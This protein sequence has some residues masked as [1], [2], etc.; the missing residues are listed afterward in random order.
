MPAGGRRTP[1]RGAGQD[2]RTARRRITVDDDQVTAVQVLTGESLSSGRQR[3]PG[4]EVDRR[5]RAGALAPSSSGNRRGCVPRPWCRSG[6]DMR[7]QAAHRHAFADSCRGTGARS[8]TS[9]MM[10][11]GELTRGLSRMQLSLGRRE[12]VHAQPRSPRE[13]SHERRSGHR[14]TDEVSLRNGE[15]ESSGTASGAKPAPSG[16]GAFGKDADAGTSCQFSDG[17][18]ER[19]RVALPAVDRYLPHRV[20]HPAEHSVLPPRPSG[21]RAD[22]SLSA[23]GSTDD[24]WIPCTVVI[25]QQQRGTRQREILRPRYP[26]PSP[27]AQH[28]P[29]G[30]QHGTVGAWYA[31]LDHGP[32]AHR[33]MRTPRRHGAQHAV[34]LAGDMSEPTPEKASRRADTDG[35]VTKCSAE[36]GRGRLL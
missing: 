22:L 18:V 25:G 33:G 2:D 5:S 20:E 26:K 19:V 31:R 10:R 7:W 4:G 8:R 29:G 1:G 14:G 28:R 15:S 11:V 16:H 23:D 35:G 13:P 9:A 27:A 21:Q 24:E 36:L 3:R 32:A 6:E 12:E 30:G 17:T 34:T